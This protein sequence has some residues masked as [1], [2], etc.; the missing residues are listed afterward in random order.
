[1]GKGEVLKEGKDVSILTFSYMVYNTLEAAEILLK[2][3]ISAEVINMPTLKPLDRELILK[4]SAKTKKVVTVEEHNIVNG[5]GS[6]VADVL[7]KDNP[8]KMIMIGVNDTFTP[9]GNYKEV[10][11]Y[12][13]LSGE[14]IASQ[15]EDF[16]S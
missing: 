2:K 16:L 11:D 8:V 7:I 3:G 13:G 14:K 1:M 4:T 12:F 6:A 15:V 10:T 5:F 9:V